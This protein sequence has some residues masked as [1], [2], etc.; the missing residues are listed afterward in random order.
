[1]LYVTNCTR[2][3]VRLERPFIIN[4]VPSTHCIWNSATILHPAPLLSLH[5]V[6]QHPAGSLPS[7]QLATG[8]SRTWVW[9]NRSNNPPPCLWFPQKKIWAWG[10]QN[11]RS[12]DSDHMGWPTVK[13]TWLLW[14]L[15]KYH[16]FIFIFLTAIAVGNLSPD[17]SH[18]GNICLLFQ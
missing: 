7:P 2:S 16:F 5:P 9:V 1:M 3:S 13:H 4:Q 6:L 14:R 17:F 15:I 10:Q 11:M 18:A 8:C 12:P